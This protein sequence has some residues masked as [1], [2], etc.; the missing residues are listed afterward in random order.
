MNAM[1]Y[2][3][4]EGEEAAW[5]WGVVWSPWLAWHTRASKGGGGVLELAV[6]SDFICAQQVGQTGSN[7]ALSTLIIRRVGMVAYLDK[8]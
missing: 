2:V 7:L 4:V 5:M 6:G 3:A 1:V 8:H